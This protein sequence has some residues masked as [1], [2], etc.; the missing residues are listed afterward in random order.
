M[1][2]RMKRILFIFA[3]AAVF[4]ACNK[5]AQQETVQQDSVVVEEVAVTDSL[6]ADSV[7]VVDS[8]VAAQ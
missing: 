2:M 7:V 5:P 8:V 6:V 4:A 3:V 1:L